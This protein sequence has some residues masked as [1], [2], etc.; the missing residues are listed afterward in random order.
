L[1]RY[2]P[3]VAYR[4]SR[5]IATLFLNL[6]ARRGWVVSTTPRPPYPRERPGT[7]A[8]EAGWASGP[9]WT[10]D[11]ILYY[12]ILYYTILYLTILYYMEQSPS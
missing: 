11:T 8:Q 10:C 7:I 5:G 9:V 1:S 4:V 12:T 2:R 6:G 3:K